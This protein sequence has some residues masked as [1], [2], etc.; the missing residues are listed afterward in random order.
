[1]CGKTLRRP[2]IDPKEI[3]KLPQ[4]YEHLCVVMDGMYRCFRV[5]A[6]MQKY[7]STR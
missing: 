1:M 2:K 7:L 5:L 6:N 4:F 3:V